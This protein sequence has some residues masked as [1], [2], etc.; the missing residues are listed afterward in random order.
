MPSLS[1]NVELMSKIHAEGAERPRTGKYLLFPAP[2]RCHRRAGTHELRRRLTGIMPGGLT[3]LLGP[4]STMLGMQSSIPAAAGPQ[5]TLQPS[6]P[7]RYPVLGA[8]ATWKNL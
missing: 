4:I 5:V 7:L 8:P 1:H 2:P 3:V 6:S